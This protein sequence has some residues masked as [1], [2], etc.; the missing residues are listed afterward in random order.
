[1]RLFELLRGIIKVMIGYLTSYIKVSPFVSFRDGGSNSW[2]YAL[3]R[4]I[5]DRCDYSIL[6]TDVQNKLEEAF[7]IGITEAQLFRH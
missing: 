4:F 5:L 2:P 3:L 6:I 1:M 7:K